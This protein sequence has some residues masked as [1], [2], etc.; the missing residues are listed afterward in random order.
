MYDSSQSNRL[1]ANVTLT[2]KTKKSV[3]NIGFTRFNI[4]GGERGI[5]TPGPV[6]VGSFQDCCNQPLCHFSGAKIILILKIQVQF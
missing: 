6:T 4:F 1:T 5:R 2:F 3:Y